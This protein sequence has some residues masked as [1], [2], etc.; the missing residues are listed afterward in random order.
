MATFTDPDFAPAGR[1]AVYYARAVE[2]P[3]LQIN[4]DNLRCTRDEAG[5][6]T[7]VN[8]C[9]GG[10]D[11]DCLGEDEERAW[12]SPIFVDHPASRASGGRAG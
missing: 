1:D 10:A 11:D 6:C 2:A 4:A 7:S 12:S 8:A 9:R 5:R 3:S